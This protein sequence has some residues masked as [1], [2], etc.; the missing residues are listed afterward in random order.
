MRADLDLGAEI[1]REIMTY[2][3]A[4]NADVSVPASHLPIALAEG[5]TLVRSVPKEE[6]L[7]YDDVV[8]PEGRLIDR[9]RSEQ[10]RERPPV[11]ARVGELS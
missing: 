6:L 4:E 2:G 11:G 10:I 7:T 8:V 3:Q 1:Y 5:C 9:L